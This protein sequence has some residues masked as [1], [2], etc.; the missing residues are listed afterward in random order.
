MRFAYPRESTF[1]ASARRALCVY[2]P[3][4]HL[5]AMWMK[6]VRNGFRAAAGGLIDTR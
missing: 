1:P 6:F 5:D 3:A 4:R 2:G